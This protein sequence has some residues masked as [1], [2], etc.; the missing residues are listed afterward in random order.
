[1]FV[2]M[3]FILES[4]KHDTK[5]QISYMTDKDEKAL[6]KIIASN[7][8]IYNL[9]SQIFTQKDIIGS[10]PGYFYII[11]PNQYKSW[12]IARAHHDLATIRQSIMKAENEINGQ[13]V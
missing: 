7:L 13:T 3:K 10:E 2:A 9:S 4:E 5:N 11:K 8:S 1:M 6:F 12:H